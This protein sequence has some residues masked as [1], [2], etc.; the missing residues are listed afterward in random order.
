MN[1]REHRCSRLFSAPVA[2]A[3]TSI[4][5]L[6]D[7]EAHRV[8]DT[9]ASQEN[10]HGGLHRILFDLQLHHTPVLPSLSG[11]RPEL[12]PSAS[13]RRCSDMAAV[14]V[15]PDGRWTRPISPL[16][17][18]S[19]HRISIF[20]ALRPLVAPLVRSRPFPFPYW[21]EGESCRRLS[22]FGKS[23]IGACSETCEQFHEFGVQSIAARRGKRVKRKK[24]H[25][26]PLG[27]HVILR[28]N[29][30]P[31]S[32]I[33][34]PAGHSITPLLALKSKKARVPA[35]RRMFRYRSKKRSLRV[36]HADYQ[37]R[38]PLT[39]VACDT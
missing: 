36:V 24:R 32:E 4:E 6:S 8:A 3:V 18:P 17:T 5:H 37:L 16:L 13:S 2:V 1:E 15:T 11:E 39:S 25:V 12:A 7:L 30:L 27:H 35:T 28:R 20:V 21:F 14:G 22:G 34:Q 9:P 10:T 19:G 26:G 38:K 33:F 23:G 29:V 31:A